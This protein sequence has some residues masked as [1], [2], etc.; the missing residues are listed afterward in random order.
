M[1]LPEKVKCPQSD[2]VQAGIEVHERHQ[3]RGRNGFLTFVYS[4]VQEMPAG[5]F[6]E[7]EVGL[8][9]IVCKSK[10]AIGATGHLAPSAP[11]RL[12]ARTPALCERTQGEELEAVKVAT[13]TLYP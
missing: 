6:G 11:P 1:A 13:R 10:K 2:P 5:F 12:H 7:C 4:V 8:T 9:F 3:R